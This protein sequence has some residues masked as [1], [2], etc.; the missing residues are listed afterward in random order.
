MSYIPS[1][2]LVISCYWRSCTL[3][4]TCAYFKLTSYHSHDDHVDGSWKTV[5]H[6]FGPDIWL[7]PGEGLQLYQHALPLNYESS[8]KQIFHI[9]IFLFIFQLLAYLSV[10][11]SSHVFLTILQGF[12]LFIVNLVIILSLFL[13]LSLSV[14]NVV[15]SSYCPLLILLLYVSLYLH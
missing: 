10:L 3:K 14:L 7:L 12:Y 9:S 8:F 1:F 2:S 6:L 11:K 4:V 13:L 15:S 5:N